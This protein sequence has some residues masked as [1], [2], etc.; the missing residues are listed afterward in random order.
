MGIF[1]ICDFS[2]LN[3]QNEIQRCSFHTPILWWIYKQTNKRSRHRGFVQWVSKRQLL[4]G[5]TECKWEGHVAP[6][7]DRCS[8][9]EKVVCFFTASLWDS[10]LGEADCQLGSGY[11]LYL[12]QTAYWQQKWGERETEWERE[13][14][15]RWDGERG[16]AF[17]N[18]SHRVNFITTIW[19]MW[20][21]QNKQ[22]EQSVD[23]SLLFEI[24]FQY[25]DYLH[26]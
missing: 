13:R 6:V 9:I 15:D 4:T 11:G 25:A 17:H 19:E 26:V 14:E 22:S 23:C 1:W 7:I 3:W 20:R 2:V 24:L 5:T 16:G 10:A 8:L 18:Y 12:L 21:L